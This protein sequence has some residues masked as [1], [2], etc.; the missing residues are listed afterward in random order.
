MD[1]LYKDQTD[2]LIGAIIKVYNSLGYGYKEKE[3][4]SAYAEELKS[5]GIVFTRE[6][7][8]Y[9][10]YNEK[11]IRKYFLDF[12][13]EFGE[14]KIVVELKVANDVYKQHFSQ[15]LQYITNN[16]IKVG[17]IFVLTPRK[18][19]I[20]RVINETPASSAKSAYPR[21]N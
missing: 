17:L 13:I 8:A 18:V 6:L 15:V 14:I 21:E 1:L 20:K 10:K 3:Y 2:K 11:I 5:L 19:I 12:L 4:Q 16:H 7:Y 9:L